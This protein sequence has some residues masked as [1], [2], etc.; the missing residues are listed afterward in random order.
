MKL[1]PAD[2]VVL[3]PAFNE[4]EVIQATLQ[5]LIA[6]GYTIVVVDDG[7][8]DHTWEQ[9]QTM[10]VHALRHAINRGQGA[11]LQTAMSYALN[12]DPAAVVHFDADGQHN[13][14]DIGALVQPI[15]DG[16]AD[17]VLGSRFL[18]P[19]DRQAVPA[20]RRLLLRLASMVNGLMT[21]MW[22]SDAH[23]GAR[24]LSQHALRSIHLQEDGFAHATEILQQ[25]RTHKLRYKEVPTN[26]RY[27]EY[28]RHKGQRFWNAFDI[29]FDLF[30]GRIFK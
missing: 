19:Q 13:P 2:I 10:P 20:A 4:G 9:L 28:S 12:L 18:R 7:S 29:L 21:G 22:L 15:S 24:A 1:T 27:T 25:I 3:I 5:K 14:A 26:I 23:N 30:L 8:A 16:D 17:I 11:A 6:V